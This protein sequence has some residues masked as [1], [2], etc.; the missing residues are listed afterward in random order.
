MNFFNIFL[1]VVVVLRNKS[2]SCESILSDISSTVRALVSDYEIVVI[3]NASN[4]DTVS[5]LKILSSYEGIPNL[6]VYALTK[7]VDIDTA[8]LVG[9][10]NALGDY[11]LVINPL[12]DDL[13]F[14]PEMLNNATSGFNV[15]F[16]KNSIIASQGLFYR[17][18]YSIF[19]AI[20]KLASGID[21]SNDAPQYKLISRNV[22][23]FILQHPRPILAYK[24]L[25][26]TGG[27]NRIN[28]SYKWIPKGF[29]A[30]K[31]GDDFNRGMRLLFST[32][33][34]PMRLV[35]SLS[36]FGASANFLYAIYVISIGFF[37]TDVASG[38]VTLSLQQSGMFF[39]IS[40]VLF[41]LGEY[42]IQMVTLSNEGPSYHVAQEFNSVRITRNEKLNIEEVNSKK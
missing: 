4:D 31:L 17:A 2:E 41:V 24:Y 26:V 33:R 1:S 11:I 34:L 7:E 28:L 6:Q 42:I 5:T 13:N 39:L 40:I 25:P 16:A 38:W 21:L 12:I 18:F 35:T 23:N 10:E 3:D 20:Y 27:F 14:L 37:K 15:V 22:I 8:S 19:N 29:P 32:T 30:K 36:L 9:L